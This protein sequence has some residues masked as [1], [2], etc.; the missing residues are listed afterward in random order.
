[1]VVLFGLRKERF[2]FEKKLT[3]KNF[4]IRLTCFVL[5]T[6]LI[7][8]CKKESSVDTSGSAGGTTNVLVGNWK[9][10]SVTADGNEEATHTFAGTNYKDIYLYKDSTT[11]NNGLFSFTKDSLIYN[12]SYDETGKDWDYSYENGVLTFAD[13]SDYS[14]PV[15]DAGGLPYK[16]KGDSVTLIDN[17]GL[18]MF[19]QNIP[20]TYKYTI[21]GNKLTLTGR[22]KF[23]EKDTLP[24]YIETYNVNI[25]SSIYLQKQ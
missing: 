18:G 21:N 5:V 16:I 3:T 2:I 14:D 17:S 12:I 8:S 13:S 19:G 9:F 4:L 6:L 24:D 22:F 11:S 23:I 25:G 7:F 1:M 20:A 15:T 10:L